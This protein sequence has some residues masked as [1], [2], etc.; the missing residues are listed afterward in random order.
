MGEPIYVLKRE[1]SRTDSNAKPVYGLY[2]NKKFDE[3][4]NGIITGVISDELC[5]IIEVGSTIELADLM[6]KN[7]ESLMKKLNTTHL[8][9]SKGPNFP[10]IVYHGK[11]GLV[12][13]K[14]VELNAEEKD[15][16]LFW[17][18]RYHK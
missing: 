15:Y 11:K 1:D 2:L 14:F 8:K 5:S 12:L 17:L 13:T 9:L 6:H 10:D 4:L 16:L 18:Y 3:S 7:L